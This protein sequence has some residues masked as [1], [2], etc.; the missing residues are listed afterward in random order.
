ML[1]LIF[2]IRLIISDFLPISFRA[3]IRERLSYDYNVCVISTTYW[4]LR[5]QKQIKL[6][7]TEYIN[8]LICTVMLTILFFVNESWKNKN[9][10][11]TPYYN[12]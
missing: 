2:S 1:I 9:Y 6:I 3:G 11:D 4:G 7:K 5:V 8:V 10:N 12:L